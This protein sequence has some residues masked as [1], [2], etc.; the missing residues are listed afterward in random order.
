MKNFP[1]LSEDRETLIALQA[2]TEDVSSVIDGTCDRAS[3][4]SVRVAEALYNA[5]YRMRIEGEWEMGENEDYKYGTCS[6]C[7]YKEFNAFTQLLPHNYCPNCGAK[8]KEREK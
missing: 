2:M 7:G 5:G 4:E 6:L 1:P 3:E 8:M